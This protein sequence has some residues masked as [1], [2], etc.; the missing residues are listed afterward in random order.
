MVILLLLFLCQLDLAP[1]AQRAKQ[2]A[3]D[4]KSLRSLYPDG[5]AQ[6]K[7]KEEQVTAAWNELITR[8]QQRKEKLGQAEE[9]QRYL[10][11]F[12]DLR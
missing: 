12:R 1:L 7:E 8:T 11:E 4:A 10:N 5:A 6:I 3:A 9:L 2:L